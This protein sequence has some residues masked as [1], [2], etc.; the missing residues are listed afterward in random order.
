VFANASLLNA[1]FTSSALPN[2]TGKTPAYAPDYVVKAGATLS[3]D[4]HYKVSLVVDSVAS[5]FFQDS[6]LPIAST[7]ARIPTYTLADLSGEY[8]FVGKL[9][10]LAGIANLT[11][12]RYYSRVFIARGQLEPGRDRTFYGGLAYDF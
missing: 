9:R 12:R 2:Q 5:Q 7:P 10:L 11:D 4:A 1:R 8:T 6:N 3:R